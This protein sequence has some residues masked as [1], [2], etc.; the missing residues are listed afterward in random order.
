M[1]HAITFISGNTGF[2]SGIPSS[3]SGNIKLRTS[4]IDFFLAV[5]AS[6]T[7]VTILIS[8]V[9]IPAPAV[10]KFVVAVINTALHNTFS[11]LPAIVLK[12][13]MPEYMC[14]KNK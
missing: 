9:F 4:C 6:V 8:P 7:H 2:I 10:L 5:T 3:V 11:G 14:F 1:M 13:H 12:Q